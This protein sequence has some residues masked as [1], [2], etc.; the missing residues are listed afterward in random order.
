MDQLRALRYFVKI[1]ELGN[2]NKA[3]AYF[4]V[5]SSSLSRRVSDLEKSLGATL[6]KRTTRVVQPTE[7]GREYYQQVSEVINQLEKSNELVRSYQSK[8]SGK[9]TISAMV[10]VGER[11]LFPLLDELREMYP[12]LIMDVHLSDELAA[13]SYDDADIAIRGG[14]A[15][16]ERVVAI[17]LIDNTFVPVAAP[18]YLARMGTPKSP[19]DL[20]Q[21][22]GLYYRTPTGPT[23]W[24]CQVDG[25]WQ[26]MSAPAKV[27]TNADQWL[28]DRAVKGE[29][30]LMVPRWILKSYF[31]SGALVELDINPP[32]TVTQK[33]GL[34]I[35][36]LYQ[37]QRYHVPKIKVAVDFLVERIKGNY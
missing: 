9:L 34:A 3:A 28:L 7:V 32:L 1:V 6:L 20:H 16:N 2:F 33:S 15:P 17:P 21:H 5:P 11:I 22:K 14:F 8:A 25:E 4:S 13:L 23:P 30:I 35:Y 27:I 19:L 29:G 31:E 36:L 12:E 24:F 18:A 26:D 37:K 10:G